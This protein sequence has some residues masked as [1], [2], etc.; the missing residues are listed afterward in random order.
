M[1]SSLDQELLAPVRPSGVPER[2]VWDFTEGAW[3]LAPCDANG[4][5]HGALRVYG[6]DGAVR[7]E[8]EYRHGKRHGPFKRY[9]SSGQVAQV[10]RY[11]DDQLDGLTVWF[12]A[13][14]ESDSI[15][16]C[17]LPPRTRVLKQE[18]RRGV[19][20]Q[21]AFFSAGGDQLLEGD[22]TSQAPEPRER[23][24]DVLLG[25][26]GFWPELEHLPPVAA[27]PLTIAQPFSELQ[28][29]I[30]RAAQRVDRCRAAL[31][32]SAPQLAPPDVSSLV[33]EPLPL[34]TLEIRVEESE[35]LVLV[36]EE[37]SL[38]GLTALE[39][40]WRARLDWTALCWLCWAAGC[41]TV[42]VPARLAPRSE[43]HAALVHAS[44]RVEGLEACVPA[45][46]SGAHFHGLEEARLPASG[47]ARLAEHYREIRAVLLFAI[48]PE[49]VSAWQEDLGRRV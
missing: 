31:L 11:F 16:T 45:A 8:L 2:A 12:S 20:L 42:A 24:D 10:G 13:G 39:V 46:Q 29:A 32:E 41:S 43:L 34:R 18:H 1:R 40:A 30:R 49:C 15:R 6:S 27:E 37:P 48:D 4:E 33:G 14:D 23:E 21:E 36:R 22:E 35:D 25:E 3:V 47:L 7:V 5:L 28:D 38:A 17:C 19:L 9:H 44:A 26:Y